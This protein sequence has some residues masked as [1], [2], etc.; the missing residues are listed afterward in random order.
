[1]LICIRVDVKVCAEHF[2]FGMDRTI[3]WRSDGYFKWFGQ[4]FWL[5]Q[6]K[7]R[8]LIQLYVPYQQMQ[9]ENVWKKLS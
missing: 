4:I 5:F 9:Q 1:M 7:L 6:N 3:K 8:R 2:D